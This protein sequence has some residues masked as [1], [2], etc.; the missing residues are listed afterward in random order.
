ML[1]ED[2]C[3]VVGAI[4]IVPSDLLWQVF[5]VLKSLKDSRWSSVWV[6]NTAGVFDGGVLASEG[7]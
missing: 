5:D 6:A 1:V 7:S 3:Q 2:V 4:N